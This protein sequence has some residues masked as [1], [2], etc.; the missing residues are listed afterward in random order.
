MH[1]TRANEVVIVFSAALVDKVMA[2]LTAFDEGIVDEGA[3]IQ[4][5]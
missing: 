4:L 2:F 1:A 5:Q 3:V